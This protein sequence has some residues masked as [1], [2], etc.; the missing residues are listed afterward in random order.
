MSVPPPEV[1]VDNGPAGSLNANATAAALTNP[2][3]VFRKL[4]GVL[5]LIPLSSDMSA[6]DTILDKPVSLF[7]F[8]KP[9]FWISAKPVSLFQ[10]MKPVS[11]F[12]LHRGLVAISIFYCL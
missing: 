7:H 1:Q 3:Y 5:F 11:L 2:R 12:H 9:V 8:M 4:A 10:I 6:Y